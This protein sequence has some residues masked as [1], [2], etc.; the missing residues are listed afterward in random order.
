MDVIE[1][2]VVFERHWGV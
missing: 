1:S 2:T